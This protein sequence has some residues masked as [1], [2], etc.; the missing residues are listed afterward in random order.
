MEDLLKKIKYECKS[1]KEAETLLFSLIEDK[2]KKLRV[3][4]A[5]DFAKKA[6]EGQFRKSGEPYI[7]HPILVASLVA[8]YGGD[9]V[10]I[11]S[12]L[13]HDV[14]EDTDHTIEDIVSIFGEEIANIVAGLTKIFDIREEVLIPSTSNE[15]LIASALSFRKMLLFSIKDV[16][17]LVIKLCDRLHNL[18]TLDALPPHKQK[19]IAEETLVVYAPI[20]HRLGMGAIK[21][22]L[23]DYSF[24]YLFPEEYK[25][26]DEYIQSHKQQLLLKLNHF[27]DKLQKLM[28]KNGFIDGSFEIQKRIK[29]YY[30]IYLKIQRK[31]ISID[32]VLDLLAV[33]ILVKEPLD[34]YKTLGIIHLNFKPLSSR[35]KDYIAIPKDNGYQTIHTSVFDD[36][37]IIEAQIRTYDMHKTAEYGVAAHWKYKNSHGL[38]PKLDWIENIKTQESENIEE[39]YE[40]AKNDL[41]SEDVSVYSPKGEVFILPKGSTV[42]DFAYAVHTEIGDRAKAGYVNKQR[43]PL[44]TALKNGDIVRIETAK[45]PIVRCSWKDSVRTAKAK[46]AIRV[47]CRNK[48]KKLNRLSAINIL[49]T[50]FDID[51]EK[52]EEILKEEDLYKK[53][54]KAATD[55]S[56]LQE[57]IVVVK[58]YLTKHK[59]L[60]TFMKLRK[61]KLKEHVKDYLKFYSVG[62]ISEVYFDYCCH[63]KIGD[64]IVA[65]LRKGN[66]ANVHHKL[67][68][69]AIKMIESHEKMVFVEWSKKRPNRYKV[70]VSLENTKGSL[71]SFLQFLAKFNINLVTIK[72][73]E[74]EEG[75]KSYFE[76]TLDFPEKDVEKIQDKIAAKY[77]VIEFSRVD[78]AYKK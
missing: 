15:K 70:I 45:E 19:R 23:E 56:F 54:H 63:P 37:S 66:E 1:V 22:K 4:N 13:L 3:K 55:H 77:K 68:S 26:I 16:R 29:H 64:D 50:I 61:F 14:V 39:F 2:E 49:S 65:F 12:A 30:S 8:A 43:V 36:K 59:M 73:G 47:A 51:A 7:V 72:L 35:F 24:A 53:I 17:V 52:I 31:G 9:D 10:M 25:K 74:S 27:I 21:N 67:C 38:Q 42:L 28:L 11:I 46:N 18:L 60:S 41:Y 6:H 40:L 33:R 69:N 78:D 76:M 58:N 62:G 5:L 20:A 44:L 57:M 34:C 32:E 75:L 48:I 71:A